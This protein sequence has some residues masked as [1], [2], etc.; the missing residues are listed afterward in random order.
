MIS[1]ALAMAVPARLRA[2]L[3]TMCSGSTP[4]IFASICRR[5]RQENNWIPR[6]NGMSLPRVKSSQCTGAQA[7]RVDHA[8]SDSRQAAELISPA[9]PRLAAQPQTRPP[10]ERMMRQTRIKNGACLPRLKK[11]LDKTGIPSAKYDYQSKTPES[12][13]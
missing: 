1:C 3:I 5:E 8:A 2:S 6:S 10:Q 7:N 4:L 11:S 12:R 9:H 13:L